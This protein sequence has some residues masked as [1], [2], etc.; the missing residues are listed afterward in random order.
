MSSSSS[1]RS[2]ASTSPPSSSSA[3]GR[4]CRRGKEEHKMGL[5][6]SSTT[7]VILQDVKVPA[8][9]VLGEVGKGHKVA[10]NVLNFGRFKLGAMTSG[11]AKD[12]I[13]DAAKYAAQR[14][15]F[16]VAI[17]T[18]G[19]IKPQTGRDDGAR[20]RPREPDLPHR[21]PDRRDGRGRRRHSLPRSCTHSRNTPS[22]RRLRRSTAAKRPTT[23]STRACRSTAATALSPTTRSS[24]IIATRASIASS[25]APTKSTGCSS[26]AC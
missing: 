22:R 6:G 26:P 9:A 23:S 3:A 25:K 11:G 5:H 14:K 24:G 19:A 12:A 1:P 17:A 8:D 2:T 21:R 18:F 20:V 7:P 16:G 15:Q 4:A 13:A 10:F